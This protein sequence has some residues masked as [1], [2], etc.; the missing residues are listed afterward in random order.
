MVNWSEGLLSRSRTVI[1]NEFDHLTLSKKPLL[2]SV[3]VTYSMLSFLI[4]IICLHDQPI[5]RIR[6]SP[7][8]P[9][10]VLDGTDNF[11]ETWY[12]VPCSSIFIMY[13]LIFRCLELNIGAIVGCCLFLILILIQYCM[14]RYDFLYENTI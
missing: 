10:N 11:L 9:T 6:I 14:Q 3:G 8:Y 7:R 12:E 4:R 2:T 5:A 13:F 1:S